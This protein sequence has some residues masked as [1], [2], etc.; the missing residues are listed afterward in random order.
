MD[1]VVLL[2]NA[3]GTIGVNEQDRN[4]THEC[5]LEVILDSEKNEFIN[6]NYE[7]C[8]S[9]RAPEISQLTDERILV[10]CCPWSILKNICEEFLCHQ[11][12]KSRQDRK[13][14]PV[15]FIP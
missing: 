5:K 1:W 12:S 11:V 13:Q 4:E 6:Q 15:S 3:V 10:E 8:D 2:M 9:G 7:E 14:G